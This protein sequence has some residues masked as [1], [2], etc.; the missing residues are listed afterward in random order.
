MLLFILWII[1]CPGIGYAIGRTRNCWGMGVVAGLFLGPIGWLLTV[2]ND[3]RE[4]CPECQGR[5]PDGARRCMHCGHR[6]EIP[7]GYVRVK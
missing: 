2:L 5:V 1:V 6:F 4:K 3:C 7:A